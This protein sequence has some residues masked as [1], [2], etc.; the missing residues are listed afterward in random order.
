MYIELN[1]TEPY[2]EIKNVKE[3][4]RVKG[5]VKIDSMKKFK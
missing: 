1:Q 5:L 4:P 2:Y 3:W